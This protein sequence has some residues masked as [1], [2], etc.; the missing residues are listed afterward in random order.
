MGNGK[1]EYWMAQLERMAPAKTQEQKKLLAA[2]G[3]ACKESAIGTR[4]DIA[5]HA[6]LRACW[7]NV[8]HAA[9]GIT[10]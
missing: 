1:K 4:Q 8:P 2:Y 7:W 6:Y 10:D 9:Y 3:E 5:E